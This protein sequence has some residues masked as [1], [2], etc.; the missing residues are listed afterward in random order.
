MA[1]KLNDNGIDGMNHPN[2]ADGKGDTKPAGQPEGTHLSEG[3]TTQKALGAASTVGTL[4]QH[5]QYAPEAWCNL[6]REMHPAEQQYL[7]SVVEFDEK[8]CRIRIAMP[9]KKDLDESGRPKEKNYKL[10]FGKE[11]FGVDPGEREALR[12]VE[13]VTYNAGTP[14]VTRDA[15]CAVL[16]PKNQLTF[17]K[18][19]A[20]C[21]ALCPTEARNPDKPMKSLALFVA[22]LGAQ[23]KGAMINGE[24]Y[25][26]T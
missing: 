19:Q 21:K 23:E 14:M 2:D 4:M 8:G 1:K 17:P 11:A 13:G 6:F 9:D 12:T 16:K 3:V 18:I 7:K 5:L 25:G 10:H 22:M 20:I 26:A 24:V 15:L